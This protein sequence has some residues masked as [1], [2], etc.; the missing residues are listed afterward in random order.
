MGILKKKKELNN[1]LKE[2]DKI[3]I[4][5]KNTRLDI[6]K[7]KKELDELKYSWKKQITTL[8]DLKIIVRTSKEYLKTNKKNRCKEAYNGFTKPVKVQKKLAD[9]I[10]MDESELTT[11]NYIWKSIYN[12]IKTNNLVAEDDKRNIVI[13]S[14]KGNI[15]KDI[16]DLDNNNNNIYSIRKNIEKLIIKD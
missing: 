14:E 12:Y 15:L 16:L 9:F 5:I 6:Q 3:E 10:K 1:T 8:K 13:D 7:K 4:E 11:R 2:V